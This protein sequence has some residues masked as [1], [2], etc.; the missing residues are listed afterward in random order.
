M[1]KI[2]QADLDSIT[3]IEIGCGTTRLLP[4]PKDIPPA[5]Y[6]DNAY[7]RLVDAIYIGAVPEHAAI[8]VR[9]GF[10]LSMGSLNRTIKALMTSLDPEHE[11][12]LAGIAFLISHVIRID[13]PNQ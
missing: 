7:T 11:D 12:K 8:A 9:E 13:P 1:Y 3:A 2:D 5:F 6:G 4:Q 10:S